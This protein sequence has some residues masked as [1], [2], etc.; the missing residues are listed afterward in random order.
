MEKTG[1]AARIYRNNICDGAACK[2]GSILFDETLNERTLTVYLHDL[3]D[4]NSSMIMN[5]HIW[6]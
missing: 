4:G 2:V 1:F 3:R 5:G 6:Y